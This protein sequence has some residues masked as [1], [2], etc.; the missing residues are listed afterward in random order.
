MKVKTINRF[1][2]KSNCRFLKDYQK[3]IQEIA[4]LQTINKHT[5]RNIN[6][7][8]RRATF[9]PPEGIATNINKGILLSMNLEAEIYYELQEQL[10]KI[11]GE[12]KSMDEFLHYMIVHFIYQ[13]KFNKEYIPPYIV[14]RKKKENINKK[15]KIKLFYKRFG[16]FMN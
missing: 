1:N 15:C 14:K 12:Y 8:V 3:V 13:Y 9:R 4:Y 5:K 10:K 2:K 7:A 11:T 16:R 6:L